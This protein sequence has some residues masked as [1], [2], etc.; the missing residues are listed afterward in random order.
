MKDEISS[1]CPERAVRSLACDVEG[2]FKF[3]GI[4][5]VG[6]KVFCAPYHASGVLV[7]DCSTEQ[8]RMLPCGE[9]A[10][11]AKP[12]LGPLRHSWT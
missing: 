11:V 8:A 5:A 10:V 2:R 9:E 3:S 6:H 4:A 7:Y 1:P 12:T